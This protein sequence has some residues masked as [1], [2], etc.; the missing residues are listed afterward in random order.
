MSKQSEAMESQKYTYDAP[1]C[2]NCV[3][4]TYSETVKTDYYGG[5]YV[6]HHSFR[7]GLGGFKVKKMSYC[8][9]HKF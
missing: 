7:C 2:S 9:E 5:E 6:Y 3:N 1:K 4:F 8:N